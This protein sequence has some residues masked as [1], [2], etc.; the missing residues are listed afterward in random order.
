MCQG[1]GRLVVRM[2]QA[3]KTLDEI[4]RGVDARFG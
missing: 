4:R 2:H 1:Q 3:G